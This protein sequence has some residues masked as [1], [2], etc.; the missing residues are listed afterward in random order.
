MAKGT[1][2]FDD[3]TPGVARLEPWLLA[4]IRRAADDA[5]HDG[6]QFEVASGWRSP[7]YQQRL[8]DEA[9]AQYGSRAEAARWVAPPDRSA[10]VSGDAVDIEPAAATDWL[11]LHG[12]QYGLCQTYANERWHYEFRPRAVEDG[13]P[14]P[15]DDPTHDPRMHG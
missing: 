6:V 4:A 12:S 3:E 1:S 13:C 2:V 9:V 10:H 5:A 15:Y 14:E 7:A 11:S 8:L